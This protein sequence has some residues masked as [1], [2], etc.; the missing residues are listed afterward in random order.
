MKQVVAVGGDTVSVGANGVR[1]NG[2]RLPHSLPQLADGQ[3][4][5]LP[6]IKLTRYRLKASELLLMTD[7]SDLSFDARY[8]G[9]L[10][11][12]Q[13]KAVIVPILTKASISH[14]PNIKG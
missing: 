4:R 10:N 13:I 5:E 1:V 12:S 8:F 11:R 9:V 2:L 6:Q 14:F 7:Q 3:G